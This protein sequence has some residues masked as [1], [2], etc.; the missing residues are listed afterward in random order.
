MTAPLI[1]PADGAPD[2]EP[3]DDVRFLQR[4]AMDADH[5]LTTHERARLLR[6]ASDQTQLY[7]YLRALDERRRP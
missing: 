1:A 2:D 4:L 7:A 3:F 5:T 6:I